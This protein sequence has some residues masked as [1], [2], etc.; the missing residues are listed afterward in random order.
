MNELYVDKLT[1]EEFEEYLFNLFKNLGYEVELTPASNDYGADLILTKGNEKIVVQAKRYSA[2]VGISAVQEVIGAKNYYKANKC[3]VVTN[4]YFTPNAIELAKSND[5]ELWDRDILI[6]MITLSLN[7]KQEENLEEIISFKDILNS[8]EYKNINSNVPLILGK[9]ELGELM[10]TTIDKMPHILITGITG[11]G[12]SMFLHMLITS[13]LYKTSPKDVRF[14]LIDPKVVELNMYNGIP[15]LLIPVISDVNKASAALSWAVVEIEKRYELFA[16]YNVRDISSYNEKCTEKIPEIV[17][18]IDELAE[19]NTEGIKNL[20]DELTQRGRAAGIYLIATT[21]VPNVANFFKNNFPSKIV[22]KLLSQSDS[23][24][25]LDTTGAEKLEKEYMFFYPS[26]YTKPLKIK[27]PFISNEEIDAI[28]KLVSVNNDNNERNFEN[29]KDVIFDDEDDL[30][31][32]AISIVVEEGQASIS[33]LQRKLKIGYARAAR[34]I[35]QMEERGLIEGYE[36]SKPRK[37]LITPEELNELTNNYRSDIPLNNSYKFKFKY[38][39]KRSILNII[40]GLIFSLFIL[41]ALINTFLMNIENPLA[42]LLFLITAFILSFKLGFL[43]ADKIF[44]SNKK[45]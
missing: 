6:K 37:V 14:V 10:I 15:H 31:P 11:T 21:Q 35:D 41:S 18:V 4:N 36:G 8:E 16:K 23:K 42:G 32:E 5:V 7:H 44:K 3:M 28:I 29:T 1:G 9:T 34:L 13:I 12:K 24:L 19:L 22:F 38:K 26:Y 33:L 20:I 30:L 40:L 25:I 27:L 39:P 17:I 43:L 2:P 45:Q